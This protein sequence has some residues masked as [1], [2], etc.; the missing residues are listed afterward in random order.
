MVFKGT[1]RAYKSMASAQPTHFN[2]SFATHA[3]INEIKTNEQFKLYRLAVYNFPFRSELI[4]FKLRTL[5]G[6]G[7]SMEHKDL[8]VI[9]VHEVLTA[10][11]GYTRQIL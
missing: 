2:I 6:A 9:T 1:T 11:Q 4:N 3:R 10:H 7:N 8:R 5:Q